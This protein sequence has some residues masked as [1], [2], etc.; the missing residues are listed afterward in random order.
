MCV[1]DGIEKRLKPSLRL[2]PVCVRTPYFSIAIWKLDSHKN[3]CVL[4]DC[5]SRL[6]VPSRSLAQGN[7]LDPAGERTSVATCKGY[8]TCDRGL[9]S[10]GGPAGH[11]VPWSGPKE[12]AWFL[13]SIWLRAVQSVWGVEIMWDSYQPPEPPMILELKTSTEVPWRIFTTFKFRAHE[14]AS[15]VTN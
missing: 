9:R 7:V 10:S 15:M 5:W 2:L 12:E 8:W 1:T 4:W 13:V 3:T 6:S 11:L 14:L